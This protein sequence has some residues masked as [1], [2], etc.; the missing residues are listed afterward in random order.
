MQK[1]IFFS[2]KKSLWPNEGYLPSRSYFHSTP[3]KITAKDW[4]IGKIQKV[5]QSS[6]GKEIVQESR[7]QIKV[8]KNLN[9]VPYYGFA[10]WDSPH[11]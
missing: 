10:K 6:H 3:G 4:L 2:P 11:H 5:S 9:S 8:M 7:L 1:S